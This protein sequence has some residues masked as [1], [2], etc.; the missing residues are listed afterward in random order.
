MWSYQYPS[1]SG[2]NIITVII[3]LRQHTYPAF[4]FHVPNKYVNL[5][6]LMAVFKEFPP[7]Q[8]HFGVCSFFFPLD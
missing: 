6:S 7:R 8:F 4:L 2:S 5:E 3:H 1:F